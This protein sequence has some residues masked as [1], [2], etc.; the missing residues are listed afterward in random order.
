L[1]TTN[2]KMNKINA[3]ENLSRLALFFFIL[4]LSL[5]S[6]SVYLPN[7]AKA[8][9][10]TDDQIRVLANTGEV[11][12]KVLTKAQ[13][14]AKAESDS[15]CEDRW[16]DNRVQICRTIYIA[17]YLGET[18]PEPDPRE[19]RDNEVGEITAEGINKRTST[20]DQIPRRVC[21]IMVNTAQ[22]DDKLGLA[23][24]NLKDRDVGKAIN[25]CARGFNFGLQDFISG[26]F[27]AYG[28]R[29]ANDIEFIACI[30]GISMADQH[31]FTGGE[32]RDF[33]GGVTTIGGDPETNA[34]GDAG[35]DCNAEGL[36]LGWVIC[37]IVEM[38]SGF[39]RYIFSDF[40]QPMMENTP[41]SLDPRDPFYKS[42]QGF[43]LI[44]NILLIGS[45]LAIVYSQARGGGGGQ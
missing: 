3:K 28:G 8:D 39:G 16:D 6:L 7:D 40:I 20:Y 15:Y 34:A 23:Y 22:G 31:I 12:G 24:K 19:L 27:N 10:L 14:A 38:V 21:E 42:W 17:A 5:Y 45:L 18:N 35:P 32:A 36:S 37:P 41:L 43:R 29:A 4:I 9:T 13:K 11:P 30:T 25:A 1:A 26:C 33:A 2:K 44:G